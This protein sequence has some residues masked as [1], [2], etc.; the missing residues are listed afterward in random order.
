MMKPICTLVAALLC[1]GLP[2]TSAAQDLGAFTYESRITG[3]VQAGG[4]LTLPPAPS[5]A[6]P[7]IVYNDPFTDGQV[8]ALDRLQHL[9]SQV[10][11]HGPDRIRPYQVAVP[12]PSYVGLI[13]GPIPEG[14]ARTQECLG[15]D[16]TYVS[17]DA[18]LGDCYIYAIRPVADILHLR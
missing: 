5:G 7:F 2:Q 15:W 9:L 18:P 8:A 17:A 11:G 6:T 1:A 16:A 4:V 14:W 12:G 3:G 10:P 13:P